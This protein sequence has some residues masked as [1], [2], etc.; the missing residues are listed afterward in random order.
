LTDS[1][2]DGNFSANPIWSGDTGN[3]QIVADS[4]VAA[5]ATG[6]NTLRLNVSTGAGTQHISTPF[7]AWDLNQ[8]WSFFFGRRAQA[9]TA[10][11]RV[12]IWLYATESDLE[13]G[14]VDGYRIT[15][16]EDPVSG[17]PNDRIILESVTDGAGTA[18]LTSS[19]DI[20]N[21][22][23]NFGIA[24]KIRR[25][26]N[27][28]WEL[29]TSDLPTTTNNFGVIASGCPLDE[30]ATSR[31]I[32]TN[33]DYTPSGTGYFG[34][35]VIHSSGAN[36]RAAQEFDQIRIK[37]D[38]IGCTDSG[39]CNYLAGATVN[40]GCDYS[41]IGCTDSGALNYDVGTTIDD[42]SCTY[43]DIIITE[44]HYNSDDGGGYPDAD[45]E[46]IELYNN[47]SFAVDLSGYEIPNMSFTFP[48]STSIAAGEYIVIALNSTTYSGNGYQVFD[49]TAGLS[50]S[51][52]TVSLESPNAVVID[53][54][55]YDT[56]S[57][58][59]TAA[60]GGGPSM[61]L[62]D[63]SFDNSLGGSWIAQ[64]VNG[65][66]GGAP[67]V[68]SGCTDPS[69]TN[70]DVTATVEDGSCTYGSA[71]VT[72]TE[73]HYNPCTDQGND[74]DYEFLELYN[75]SGSTVDITG[76]ELLGFEYT[77]P[78][79]TTIAAGEYIIVVINGGAANYT[80]SYQ[81]F[82]L[83][84]S[85][86][87]MLNTGESIA[88]LDGSSN[89]IDYVNYSNS[90]PWPTGADG[91][92]SS[93]EVINT[94]SGNNYPANWQ[95][96]YTF[97]GTPGAQNSTLYECSEC[98]EVGAVST[99][100]LDEDWEAGALTGWTESTVADWTADNV[101]PIA[102]TYSLGH[103]LTTGSG[104]SSISYD[105]ECLLYSG[106]CTTWQFQ[107]ENG[108]WDPDATNRFLVYLLANEAD[109]QSSTVDGYA[110]GL[111]YGTNND[112]LA[113]YYMVDG[114]V[115]STLMESNVDFD[116][117]N[118]MGIEVTRDQAGSWMLSL[119]VNGGFDNL[120]RVGGSGVTQTS[121]TDAQYFGVSFDY[122]G[123]SVG[124]L[125]VDDITVSQCGLETIYYSTSS[126][127]SSAAIWDTDDMAVTGST[128]NFGRYKRL[129]VQSGH[130]VT[131]DSDIIAD[132]FSTES[133]GTLDAT[134]NGYSITLF[135][136]LINDGSFT[137]G[138]S[139]VIMKGDAAQLIA[140]AN[141]ISLYDLTIEN[142]TTTT[143]STGVDLINILYANKGVL[144]SAGN[145][146]IFS[147]AST[148]AYIGPIASGASIT[149]DVVHIEYLTPET[150]AI[151]D[152]GWGYISPATT[153]LTIADW[154]DDII[155]TG[156][157][158]SDY[159]TS[160]FNNLR[161]YDEAVTGNRNIGWTV[162]TNTTNAID[163]DQSYILWEFENAISV[164]MTGP[165]RQGAITV[166]L[167]HTNNMGTAADGWNLTHNI[168]AAPVDIEAL[169][170]NSDPDPSSGTQTAMSYYVWDMSTRSYVIYQAVTGLGTGSRYLAPYQTFL[171]N[172]S[173][174]HF[175]L[176]YDESVKD[177]SQSGLNFIRNEMIIPTISA[178][179]SNDETHDAIFL[180]F[181]ENSSNG[182]DIFDAPKM[183]DPSIQTCG[184][185]FV[186]EN[187]EELAIDSRP[188][189]GLD[190]LE[191][192]VFVTITEAGTYS[193]SIDE[194]ED[195]PA[196][197][198]LS[199]E[200]LL[201]GEILPLVE[202]ASFSLSFEEAFEGTAFLIS[203][204]QAVTMN[205]ESASCFGI[206]D[207][208]IEVEGNGDGVFNF[209]WVDENDNFVASST[210]AS[211]IIEN[212]AFGTYYLSISGDDL[213]CGALTIPVNIEQPE[214][215]TINTT[216]SLAIC[217]QAELADILIEVENVEAY[218][219]SLSLN[220]NIL[221]SETLTQGDSYLSELNAEVYT[222]TV[223][224]TCTQLVQD[225]DLRDPNAVEASF[226]TET[227]SFML[228]NGSV[229][230]SFENE[231]SGAE[232]YFW[233]LGDGTVSYDMNPQHI[234]TEAG[235]YSIGLEAANLSCNDSFLHEIEI[236]EETVGVNDINLENQIWI[237]QNSESVTLHFNGVSSTNMRAEIYDMSGRL[238]LS[239]NLNSS[240]S[241][242]WNINTSNMSQAI[243]SI[244]V[245]DGVNELFKSKFS[246]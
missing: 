170:S 69:A 240:Q 58:W 236:L 152:D 222:M 177:V 201:S 10:A 15:I 226:N 125:W 117:S 111:N 162:A 205:T 232:N 179:I 148:S 161:Y 55:T 174:T 106:T 40:V 147:D 191:I 102:G 109:L 30:A 83:P 218:S 57:P 59:P 22:R 33:T 173:A 181:M 94:G 207:G 86:P 144:A 203:A 167:S 128:L 35:T 195:M 91:N 156:F 71:T 221:M 100:I 196:G 143:L 210:G 154:D 20:V 99:D 227:E 116:A 198:C 31:G 48:G 73:L 53:T 194:I 141:D 113:L 37:G 81:V 239:E 93:L 146:T 165:V 95:A 219:Y 61:E 67:A 182:M 49:T 242:V 192:P 14:T 3:W 97:G 135:G 137:Y 78:A 231:S 213:N 136:N 101:N 52:E 228:S 220:G 185:A 209:N 39:A 121:I 120:F 246:K 12:Q 46:F 186:E 233:S 17:I 178:S 119:D 70:Y 114:A 29:L 153:G 2:T 85:G 168:Y 13:S 43:P 166:D 34:F 238:I 224:S 6:S 110:V 11:N 214:P 140:G 164:D 180:S 5:G 122:T 84:S 63:L 44:I 9:L 8:T 200:N 149:G 139:N 1:F 32:A 160:L 107:V 204:K 150:V 118:V 36:G 124:E 223:I 115:S 80:G 138:N 65:T 77:F 68:I 16:G 206:E 19:T 42:A 134:T 163:P 197:M 159:P 41:C 216:T 217:N 21:S 145:L 23:T 18:V 89:Y 92:C 132:D 54:V 50:N 193:F 47:E 74:G 108:A 56:S 237:S 4:D 243:Y 225:I 104:T 208:K 157:T 64:S 187:G 199:I 24:F 172:I 25:D 105:M 234:Y 75:A 131:L 183:F 151:G 127:N 90:S 211:S 129:V 60:D 184:A 103:N 188:I 123:S 98:G 27:G 241:S 245:I 190:G 212:L 155:T 62:D 189:P 45:Y 158:G 28:N 130:T 51:G 235:I 133:T 169:V 215:E 176:E 38:A 82:E 66:P 202:G 112:H 230:V 175:D 76:W 171:C 96:S 72:I 26:G 126:G 142:S 88:L 87:S 7:T 79:T 244:R 229:V